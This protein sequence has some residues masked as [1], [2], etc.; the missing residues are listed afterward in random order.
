M[1]PVDLPI[2]RIA[3]LHLITEVVLAGHRIHAALGRGVRDVHA[4]LR[5]G[6]RRP[7]ILERSS[8][9]VGD[10]KAGILRIPAAL[11][12]GIGGAVAVVDLNA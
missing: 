11:G 2:G 7:D 5:E 10:P 4:G 3:Q 8:A 1:E 6:A 12:V 9:T